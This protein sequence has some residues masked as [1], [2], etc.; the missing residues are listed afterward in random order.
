M[1]EEFGDWCII[2]LHVNSSLRLVVLTLETVNPTRQDVAQY[3]RDNWETIIQYSI[4]HMQNA[5]LDLD[6]ETAVTKLMRADAKYGPFELKTIDAFK[7]IMEE[8]TDVANYTA[9]GRMQLDDRY[10]DE[11]FI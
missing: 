5:L 11:A 6:V 7:E 4:I 1:E 10:L 9:M 2:I 3:L 8:V